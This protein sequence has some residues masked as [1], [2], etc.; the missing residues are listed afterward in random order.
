MKLYICESHSEVK[1]N[2]NYYWNSFVQLQP[3]L[4]IVNLQGGKSAIVIHKIKITNYYN[5][6]W[7]LIPTTLLTPN[8]TVRWKLSLPSQ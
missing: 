5:Y 8:F 1:L 6:N 4:F 2:Y 7:T 3:E